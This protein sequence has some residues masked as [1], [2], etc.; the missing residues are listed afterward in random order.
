MFSALL[1]VLPLL[2]PIDPT[3]RLRVNE[4]HARLA[5]EGGVR[6]LE[7]RT[8]ELA[9]EG[10][11]AYVEAGAKSTLELTWRGR[12]SATVVGPSSFQFEEEPRLL[13][14]NFHT[15]E[16]EARRAA[17][18]VEVA[19]LAVFTLEQGAVQLVSTSAGLEVLNRGGRALTLHTLEGRELTVESGR[20]VRI[21]PDS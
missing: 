17:F 20:R 16:L 8:G 18:E 10:R 14:E 19:G 12:A 7:R 9:V 2:A 1:L 15:A 6:E 4:G 13:L 21:T 3:P 5:L 11:A